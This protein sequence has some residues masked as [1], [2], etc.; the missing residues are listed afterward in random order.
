MGNALSHIRWKEIILPLLTV[1]VVAMIIFPLPSSIL[2]VLLAANFA[3]CIVLLL[4][5][6]F[7]SEPDKFTSLP[8]LLL[9][10]TLFRLGLNISST[11]VILSGVSVPE[12]ITAFGNFVVAG[13]TI[14]GLVVFSIISI[15]QFIVVAKGSER[16]AEVAARF[17]LDALPGKQMSIDADMRAGLLNL[18]EAREKRREL[19]RESKLY[20]ALDGAMKF[21]KGDAI[22]GLCI[23]FVNIVAGFIVGVTRDG[24][25]LMHAVE[26]YTLFTIG[27][28]LVSQIPAVLVS[29]AAGIV[30]T[31]VSEKEG[32]VLSQEIVSQ[33]FKEPIVLLISG[34]VLFS[35]GFVP[36]LPFIP[37]SIVSSMPIVAWFM[38]VKRID[39]EEQKKPPTPF[40]PR[41]LPVLVIKL[42]AKGAFLLQ[43]ENSITGYIEAIRS[44]VFDTNGVFLPDVCFDVD[45]G[46]S[47]IVADL[48]IN[49]QSRG[50]AHFE[51][52][53]N[54]GNE[55][56]PWSRVVG[57]LLKNMLNKHLCEFVD[58]SH[59][60][61]LLDLYE[62]Y[63]LDVINAV[64]PEKI[65]ITGLTLVLRNLV[66]E[67]ISI[68]DFACILQALA[69][70]FQSI[71]RAA[72]TGD[73]DREVFE[74]VRAVRKRLVPKYINLQFR[75]D[76]PLSVFTLDMETEERLITHIEADL[77]IHPDV[78]DCIRE[79]ILAHL[80]SR[81]YSKLIILVHSRIRGVLYPSIKSLG[82]TL[83]VISYEEVPSSYKIEVVGTIS[84]IQKEVLNDGALDHAA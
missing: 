9:L 12:V 65:S 64:V 83:I 7:I 56:D 34:V 32:G 50:R 16:V 35:L 81:K 59:T 76:I 24:L 18:S 40:A 78:S 29:V 75:A 25:P 43:R 44:E 13:S 14:V 6:L 4:S 61:A 60:R 71:G 47:G 72:I 31:R 38:A 53:N 74:A 55:E 11:R 62:V 48:L 1:L 30:V 63:H 58:D 28:G 19:H 36:G 27:D 82:D 77:S 39:K 49:S 54:Q 26:K 2:D 10:S 67:G 22:V 20:G 33:L 66:E 42:S 80:D 23:I 51:A 70:Y 84:G 37:F 3:F 46:Q 15:I 41:I 69:E 8:T 73:G 52:E 57:R 68:R 5:S 17:T 45:P 79:N 21:V